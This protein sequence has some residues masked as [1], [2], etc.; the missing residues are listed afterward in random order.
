MIND[1]ALIDQ[2]H[3]TVWWIIG[4]IKYLRTVLS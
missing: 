1:G 3:H 4:V 2:P